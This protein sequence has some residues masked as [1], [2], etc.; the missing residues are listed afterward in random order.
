MKVMHTTRV[1]LKSLLQHGRPDRKLAGPF[2]DLFLGQH[3]SP[4]VAII[5]EHGFSAHLHNTILFPTNKRTPNA[6][7]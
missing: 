1:A 7:T 6:A 4:F 2:T 3:G 5:L